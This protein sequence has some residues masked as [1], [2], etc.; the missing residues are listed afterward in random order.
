MKRTIMKSTSLI[1]AAALTLSL[2]TPGVLVAGG[3]FSDVNKGDWY[4]DVVSELV[5]QKI[6]NGYPDGTFQ[7]N[8]PMTRIEVAA[9]AP[10][11]YPNAEITME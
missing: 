1:C 4:Y 6:V 2:T 5:D 11:A 10:H 3:R 8:R 9:L 7:P